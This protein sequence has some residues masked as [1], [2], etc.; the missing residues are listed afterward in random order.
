MSSNSALIIH[1]SA[2][3]VAFTLNGSPISVEID[4]AD[5]LLDTLRYRLGLTGTKEGCGEGECGACTVYLDGLPVNSCL[6]PTY[7]VRGR[8]VETVEW[9]PPARL[10]PLL[11]H[12]ATQCGACTPG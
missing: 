10:D 9:L 11:T 5:R 7:Q 6:V 1:H 2:F 4:P 3:T 8:R 12:G